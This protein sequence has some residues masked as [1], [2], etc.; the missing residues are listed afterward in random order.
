MH[1]IWPELELQQPHIGCTSCLSLSY[2]KPGVWPQQAPLVAV[3][4]GGA[5]IS[6]LLIHCIDV[7]LASSVS[8][9]KVK[10]LFL[11]CSQG[12]DKSWPRNFK[13]GKGFS[14]RVL[15]LS[16]NGHGTIY[17]ATI[18]THLC[19]AKERLCTQEGR[20][21]GRWLMIKMWLVTVAEAQGRNGAVCGSQGTMWRPED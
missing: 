14:A 6:H 2:S 15:G 3:G 12:A 21:G 8:W 4:K 5:L 10:K 18:C 20:C 1:P 17:L 16:S 9:V 7:Y 11:L 13:E 19:L